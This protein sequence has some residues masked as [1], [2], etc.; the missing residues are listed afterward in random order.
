MDRYACDWCGDPAWGT[1]KFQFAIA[2]SDW[3]SDHYGT[4]LC[5]IH[6]ENRTAEGT[7]YRFDSMQNGHHTREIE[8]Q[9]LCGHMSSYHKIHLNL[10][11]A[12]T[13]R[14]GLIGGG[15]YLCR[16]CAK[17]IAAATRHRLRPMYESDAFRLD[18]PEPVDLEGVDEAFDDPL[19]N[20]SDTEVAEAARKFFRQYQGAAS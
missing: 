8:H 9:C 7:A 2:S 18:G 4:Q 15:V 1:R 16:S 10:D 12:H 14:G 13:A 19:A 17:F 5:V 11:H 6:D 3:R 20:L